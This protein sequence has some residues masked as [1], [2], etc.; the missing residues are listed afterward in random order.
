MTT[1]NLNKKKKKKDPIDDFVDKYVGQRVQI[2]REALGM[3]IKELA[4]KIKLRN[5]QTL[6]QS[7]SGETR[8]GASR[9]WKLAK[10]M[11]VHP[12][13]F[14]IGLD[15][16]IEKF[17]NKKQKTKKPILSEIQQEQYK[18]DDQLSVDKLATMLA[19][20]QINVKLASNSRISLMWKIA[21]KLGIEPIYFFIALEKYLDK[22]KEDEKNEKEQNNIDSIVAVMVIARNNIV[23]IIQYLSMVKN[24]QKAMD[25]IL[26]HTE[27]MV[28]NLVQNFIK[29]ENIKSE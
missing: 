6:Q 14:F 11:N 3:S 7:E 15:E 21:H 28:K 18:T 29:N 4:K 13:Y 5:Y 20:Q 27:D 19:K 25:M 9:L 1:I 10:A 2:R 8:I 24:N 26:P 22:I 12:T 16:E 23:K 17:E